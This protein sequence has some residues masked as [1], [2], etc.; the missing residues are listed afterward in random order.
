[1]CACLRKLD[2]KLGIALVVRKERVEL[3]REGFAALSE[4]KAIIKVLARHV[5]ASKTYNEPPLDLPIQW[6]SRNSMHENTI[7]AI[8]RTRG[9]TAWVP[10]LFVAMRRYLKAEARTEWFTL[11]DQSCRS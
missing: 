2:A 11:L 6:K 4:P 9:D 1:M 7:A 8:K 5:K 10:A 3:S